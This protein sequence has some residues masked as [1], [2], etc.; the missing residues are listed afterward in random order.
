[1]GLLCRLDQELHFTYRSELLAQAER[2]GL[3][4]VVQSV[5]SGWSLEQS[6]SDLRQMRCRVIVV[7]DPGSYQGLDLDGLGAPAVLVG[8]GP[9]DSSHDLVTSD[10][11]AGMEEVVTHLAGQGA[12][13]VAY[14]DGPVGRSASVRREAFLAAAERAG[15]QVTVVPAGAGA[16]EGYEAVMTLAT[17]GSLAGQTPS[18]TRA[19]VCYN[20]QCAQGAVMAL[21]RYCLRPGRDV[22]VTGCDDT[23]IARSRAF[24]LTSISR[25]TEQVAA[26]IMDL[27]R[28]RLD[29]PDRRAVHAIVPTE[30]VVRGSS[31]LAVVS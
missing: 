27:V 24:D 5:D 30:L 21:S 18:G 31:R 9:F 11:A 29:H 2:A 10:N 19:L 7:I 12:L 14:L 13:R 16:D 23:R 1:M 15:L 28:S 25:R 4:L 17:A 26:C 8:Q 6:L 20:D 3:R 22:A